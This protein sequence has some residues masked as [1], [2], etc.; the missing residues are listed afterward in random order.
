MILLKENILTSGERKGAGVIY[1]KQP[2]EGRMLPVVIDCRS[3]H[4]SSVKTSQPGVAAFFFFFL[5][6]P[7]AKA[8]GIWGA[9]ILQARLVGLLILA[10]IAEET[11]SQEGPSHSSKDTR[12]QGVEGG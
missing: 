9:S 5:R 12:R 8:T 7:Q 1:N 3:I 4:S 2:R 10:F 11:E 6:L